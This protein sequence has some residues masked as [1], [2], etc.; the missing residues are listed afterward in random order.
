ML[1]LTTE[2]ASGADKRV[3]T[4][5]VRHRKQRTQRVHQGASHSGAAERFTCADAGDAGVYSSA[6]CHVG[7]C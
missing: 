5:S 3:F 4:A 6:N 1:M 2:P 7:K